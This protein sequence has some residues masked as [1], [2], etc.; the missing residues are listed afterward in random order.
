MNV[1]T[2][3]YLVEYFLEK[4]LTVPPQFLSLSLQ[5]TFTQGH[6]YVLGLLY[7]T[8]YLLFTYVLIVKIR[9]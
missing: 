6:Y 3:S 2:I 9:R 8:Y 5:V 1:N 4:G 7:Y